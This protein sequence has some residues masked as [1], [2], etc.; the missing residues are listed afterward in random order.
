[1]T[2]K[3][4]L[5]LFISGSGTNL[6]VMIDAIERGELD[7]EIV[8]VV[9]NKPNAYGLTRAKKHNIP[10]TILTYQGELSD[11]KDRKAYE[12]QLIAHIEQVKPA[13]IQLAGWNLVL[14][15]T[16]LKSMKDHEIPVINQHP[17]LLSSH[18]SEKVATSR[19]S[20]PV[21]RG[22]HAIQD[23]F[24][25]GLPVSGFTVHQVLPGDTFDIGPIILKAEVRRHVDD[26]IE[27][28]EKRIRKT[29]YLFIVTAIK[30][31][32]HV[33]KHGIDISQGTFPW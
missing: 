17:A 19:G 25:K 12:A 26:T 10:T 27:S 33:M 3:P 28:W 31:A 11:M 6:Q 20:I 29:E 21:I 13:L 16:F 5:C 22:I 18:L 14:G 23:A 30:R 15:E 7:A 9:S 8:S 1:M 4:K 2:G 24:T 32:L